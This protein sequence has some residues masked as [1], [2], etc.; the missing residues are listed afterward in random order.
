MSYLNIA[1]AAIVLAAVLVAVGELAV[2]A[3]RRRGDR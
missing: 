2:A 3:W 1:M